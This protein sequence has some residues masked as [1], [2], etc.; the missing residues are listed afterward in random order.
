MWRRL[1]I[2]AGKEL[3]TQRKLCR[4]FSFDVKTGTIHGKVFYQPNL[5]P[6]L[7]RSILG[8]TET[9]QHAFC[10]C[11]CNK[12][13]LRTVSEKNLSG[14]QDPVENLNSMYKS[15]YLPGRKPSD[16]TEYF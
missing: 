14:S 3:I 6:V 8:L 16:S 2:S 10:I 5:T 13:T 1:K 9:F 7:F 12:N 15:S 11:I 4:S